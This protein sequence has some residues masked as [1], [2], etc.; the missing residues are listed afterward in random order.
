M[1][2]L[3]P[4][5]FAP[6]LV[7][8]AI[9]FA[10]LY[11]VLSRVALPRIE[12]VLGG[13]KSR[14]GSDLEKA[15]DA[16]QRSEKEMERYEA[17]IAAAKAKGQGSI[18]AAREKLEAEL[19]QKREVLDHQLAAKAAE[20]EK[21]VQNLL[22]RASGEMEEMTAGVVSDIVREFAGAEVSEGEVRAALRQ[23]P[24]E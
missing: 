8:L 19:N 15:R 13:R 12:K 9:T 2:Q 16:Q 21:R 6:Q 3:Q 10:F 22:E 17:E 23:S 11:L 20:T 4:V 24:K 18:R 14:I 7:W 5:D 1:P